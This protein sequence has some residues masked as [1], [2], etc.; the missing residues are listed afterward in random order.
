MQ[1]RPVLVLTAL[2]LGMSIP[3]AAEPWRAEVK[4]PKP[5]LPAVVVEVGY[6]RTYVPA[7]N[8]PIAIHATAG[9]PG[10]D[11]YLGYRF[12]VKDWETLDSAVT[13]RASIRPHEIW[14]FQTFATLRNWGTTAPPREVVIEWRDRD[15]KLICIA[16]AGTPDWIRQRRALNIGADTALSD[17]AQWYAGY[18]SVIV[19]LDTWLDLKRPVRDAI[20]GSAIEV[21]FVGFARSGQQLDETTRA[22]LPVEFIARPG[23]YTVPWPYV[24]RTVTAPTSWTPKR[25]AGFIGSATCPYLA[26]T[27]TATW[28]ADRDALAR[29]LPDVLHF[30]NYRRPM[31]PYPDTRTYRPHAAAGI[32]LLVI[33]AGWV[34]VRR[35]RTALAVVLLI[36][37]VAV[38]AIARDRIRQKSG[39]DDLVLRS[40]IAPGIAAEYRVHS[41][42]GPSPLPAAAADRTAVTGDHMLGGIEVRTSDTPPSM[43]S[44]VFRE[45]WGWGIRWTLR[46]T[47]AAELASDRIDLLAGRDLH[48]FALAEWTAARD[49]GNYVLDANLVPSGEQRMS[50][51]LA[52]PADVRTA[53]S[54]EMRMTLSLT[55]GPVEIK[56]ATGSIQ[57]TPKRKDLTSGFRCAIPDETVKA[58]E[59]SGGVFEINTTLLRNIVQPVDRL[60][61]HVQEKS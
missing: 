12:A 24:A 61:V 17:R 3:A 34:F 55:G 30:T 48:E 35:N 6:D 59:A 1:S 9:D 13:S 16:I 44:L 40:V 36:G 18:S 31:F 47:I 37:C 8:S 54:V 53:R 52:L 11:G 50:A 51:T 23:A 39:T 19:P 14:T 27:M 7:F 45:D 20:F 25:G 15:A 42:H 38:I 10:F 29:P 26:R 43:G 41:T 46:R 22:L 4:P 28:V 2:L 32:A 49:Q 60:S 56:W 33:A 5:G 58:I 57:L 21:V